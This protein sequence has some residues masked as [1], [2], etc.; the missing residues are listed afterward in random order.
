MAAN[1]QRTLNTKPC[2]KKHPSAHRRKRLL[3]YQ[4]SAGRSCYALGMTSHPAIPSL[5]LIPDESQVDYPALYAIATAYAHSGLLISAH[6]K[7]TDRP[8]L[9]FPAVVCSSFAIELFLKFFLMLERADSE[10][11]SA[12]HESGHPLEPLWKKIRPAHQ[13]L[14]AGMFR[15]KT[16]VPLLNASDK[17]IELF[18]EAIMHL[19]EAKGPF[20]K[21][22]YAHELVDVTFM[23]HAAINEVL[24]ALGYAA[25]YVMKERSEVSRSDTSTPEGDIIASVQPGHTDQ[26]N[27]EGFLLVRGS[28]HL[29]LGRDSVLRQIPVNVEPKQALFL[30]G[31]R[32]AVEIMDI[33]YSRLRDA[34]THLALHPP[35]SNELPDLSACAF[36]DAWMLTPT[37]N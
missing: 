25:N 16:G 23:S 31:I 22:R 6:G 26:P 35:A 21:W 12:K 11:S 1:G 36:L 17:R 24:D 18:A 4:N 10:E 37:E 29:L 19:G 27:G 30:D 9:S 2:D 28:E 20:V 32:H 33:A 13:A 5:V 3:R 15:N 14:I 7:E 8:E 34:L